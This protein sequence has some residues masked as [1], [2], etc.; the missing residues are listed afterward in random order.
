MSIFLQKELLTLTPRDQ[1]EI[2]RELGETFK[3]FLKAF[4]TKKKYI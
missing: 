1:T 2:E 3:G 4:N